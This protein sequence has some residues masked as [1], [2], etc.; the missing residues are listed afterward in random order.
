MQICRDIPSIRAVLK[1]E[2]L[3]DRSIGF[4]PTMGNLHAGHLSLVTKARELAEKVVVSI[5]VNPTQFGANEDLDAYPRTEANDLALL[6]AA[7]VDV[8][9]LPTV[10]AMYPNGQ[11]NLT[12]VIVPKLTETLCGASRPGHF[13]GV[14][15]VVTKLFNIVQ[16]DLAC[17]GAKDYQQLR[18]V[19]KMVQDLAMNVTVVAVPT[20]RADDGL[21]LSSRNQYLDPDERDTAPK[22]Q[23]FMQRAIEQLEAGLPLSMA[24]EQLIESLEHTGFMIDYV[25]FVRPDDLSVLTETELPCTLAVAAKLGSTRLIDNLPAQDASASPALSK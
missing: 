25:E 19:Q 9:F 11:D 10:E 17:F 8:V 18:V 4:V 15:S 14:S 21:A 23:I 6:E 16:P 12:E 3:A 7:G 24:R 13:N 22:L 20:A 2:R 1:K 5:F